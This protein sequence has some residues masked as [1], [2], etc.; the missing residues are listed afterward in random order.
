MK[1]LMIGPTDIEIRPTGKS[2]EVDFCTIA[3]WHDGEIVEENL[4]YDLIGMMRQ[5]GLGG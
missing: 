2:F 4:S 1:G 5:L 3:R